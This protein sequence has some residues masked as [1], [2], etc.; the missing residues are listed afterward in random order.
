[1]SKYDTITNMSEYL[2]SMVD[3][4]FAMLGSNRNPVAFR[5]IL[6]ERKFARYK[7]KSINTTLYRLR[8]Q[9][10]TE[11]TSSGWLLTRKGH[12]YVDE[13]NRLSYLPTPFKGKEKTKL[14]IAFDI[15][16]QDK[17]I[18]DWLRNQIKI[19]GYKMV[20]QSLW[21]GPGPLPK[22]FKAR[23]KLLDIKEKVKI[24]KIVEES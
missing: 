18:R 14:M 13:K 17:I 12:Q 15:P 1:M 23:L 10:F 9:G 7:D 2:E 8:K 16:V 4:I 11:N 20:Q 21:V 6:R 22:A 3:I 5:R 19:F 24:F